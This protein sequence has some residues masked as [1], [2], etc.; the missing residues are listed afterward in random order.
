MEQLSELADIHKP[1][2]TAPDRW[3]FAHFQAGFVAQCSF[4]KNSVASSHPPAGNAHR[5]AAKRVETIVK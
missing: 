4:H 5:C 1:P 2:N 3:D